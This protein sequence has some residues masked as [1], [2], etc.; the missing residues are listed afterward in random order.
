MTGNDIIKAASK[1]E[2]KMDEKTNSQS[3]HHGMHG[4][5]PKFRN[6]RNQQNQGSAGRGRRG[7]GPSGHPASM[8]GHHAPAQ[9]PEETLIKGRHLTIKI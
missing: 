4:G 1:N 3:F 5:N 6:E 7:R 9:N 8:G 2:K